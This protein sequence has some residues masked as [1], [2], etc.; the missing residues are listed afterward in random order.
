MCLLNAME[1]GR[2]NGLVEKK[3]ESGKAEVEMP[4]S[5]KWNRAGL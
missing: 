4:E 5:G 1:W 2:M 3:G